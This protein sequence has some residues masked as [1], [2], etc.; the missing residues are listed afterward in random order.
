M[1]VTYIRPTSWS[2]KGMLWTQDGLNPTNIDYT[3][4]LVYALFE[5]LVASH[6]FYRDIIMRGLPPIE[7]NTPIQ[8]AIFEYLQKQLK[9]LTPSFYKI[10]LELTL[11]SSTGYFKRWSWNELNTDPSCRICELPVKGCPRAS[12]VQW[13]IH[14]KNY[15]NKLVILD[16]A[17]GGYS[18]YGKHYEETGHTPS[19]G[20]DSTV[21]QSVNY[22]IKDAHENQIT[23]DGWATNQVKAW[24][25]TQTKHD[26]NIY[27]EHHYHSDAYWLYLSYI[28]RATLYGTASVT[29]Y[30]PH[31]L[32]VAYPTLPE[33]DA[34]TCIFDSDGTLYTKDTLSVKNYGFIRGACSINIGCNNT[35][36]P[37]NTTTPALNESA[38]RGFTVS[39]WVKEDYGVSGGFQFRPDSAAYPTITP[40][41]SPFTPFIPDDPNPST[42]NPKP[43]NPD[44]PTDPST[45]YPYPYPYNPS[46]PV[47]APK[48][49]P[50]YPPHPH[51]P[52]PDSK[53]WDY[54]YY[55]YGNQIS[56]LY[57]NKEGYW[58]LAGYG[59]GIELYI[60]YSKDYSTNH[61]SGVVELHIDAAIYRAEGVSMN[62]L[63]VIGG[64][65]VWVGRPGSWD[66]SGP[67]EGADSFLGDAIFNPGTML[68]IETTGAGSGITLYND[69]GGQATV[70][71]RITN[72][73][74]VDIPQGGMGSWFTFLYPDGATY[75]EARQKHK[76]TGT[77]P[78][79]DSLRFYRVI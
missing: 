49:N 68:T 2:D 75:E 50:P 21:E 30:K 74:T 33:S 19:I 62:H 32:V 13:M 43:V 12:V 28:K 79:S 46:D 57:K 47:V 38:L 63:L 15:L 29:K 24:A 31:T 58:V 8:Y 64:A 16:G 7:P 11:D 59:D 44:D 70:A 71:G 55:L 78:A 40:P 9:D 17:E 3:N 35:S 51:N 39:C 26:K 65:S 76:F 60:G 56:G 4:A 25:Y 14:A 41:E 20:I 77:V 27:D 45:P 22:A 72:E 1:A 18:F 48:H 23:Y 10:P 5:R 66:S 42:P 53:F 52:T 67:T 6:A 34:E 61:L 37:A 73:T 54:T 36:I 69:V